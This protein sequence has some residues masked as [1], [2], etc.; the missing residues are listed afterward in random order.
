MN[1]DNNDNAT[2]NHEPVKNTQTKEMPSGVMSDAKNGF[3]G[4]D[5]GPKGRMGNY[6]AGVTN[7]E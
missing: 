6:A 7:E 5:M 3:V 4:E 2:V 1:T